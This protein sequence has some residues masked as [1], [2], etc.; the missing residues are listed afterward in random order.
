M[1]AA[2]RV[3]IVDDHPGIVKALSR[4]LVAA[5]HEVAGN[6]ADFSAVPETVRHFRPD[7]IVLD[8]NLQSVDGLEVCRR[9]T[10][11]DP[12]MKV[13]VFTAADDPDIRQRALQAGAVDFVDKR[14]LEGDLLSAVRRLAASRDQ[15][16]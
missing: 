14:S 8:V 15:R 10:Q 6:I 7:L 9:I 5:G 4:L 16:E 13:I 2:L 12:Q 11:A 3:L 1:S